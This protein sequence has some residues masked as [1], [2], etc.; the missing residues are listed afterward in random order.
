MVQDL[1][2]VAQVV[3]VASVGGFGLV[4]DA[5]GRGSSQIVGADVAQP[6]QLAPLDH[7]FVEGRGAECP[8]PSGPG[9]RSGG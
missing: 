4:E 1:L 7:H 9:V 3:E 2:D 6:G 5:E 8:S